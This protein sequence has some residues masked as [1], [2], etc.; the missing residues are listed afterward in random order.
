MA[1]KRKNKRVFALSLG[2]SLFVFLTLAGCVVVDTQG[3]R[4]SFG[5]DQPPFQVEHLPNDQARLDV[6]LFGTDTSSDFTQADR[7]LN[8]VRDFF[9]LPQS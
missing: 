8:M 7:V 1:M 5:D 6:K 4:L 3:R 9:C 2:L